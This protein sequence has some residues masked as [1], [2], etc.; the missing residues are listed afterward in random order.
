[1][2]IMTTLITG[3]TGFIG[4]YVVRDLLNEGEKVVAYDLIPQSNSMSH[5]LPQDVI[6]DLSIVQGEI[7]DHH[8]LLQT[9]KEYGVTQIVHLASPLWPMAQGN[10]PKAL[11]DMC[12]G[13]VN[14]LETARILDMRRVVWGSSSAV[15]G[16]R[17]Q[18]PDGYVA[19]DAPHYPNS[20]YGACKSLCEKY[21]EQY[22]D[23]YNLDTIGLRFTMVYGVGRLRGHATFATNLLQFPAIGEE[24]IVGYSDDIIDWQYVEDVAECIVACLKAPT[25]KTRVFTVAGEPRPVMD[26]VNY[27]KEL[28]PDAKLKLEKGTFGLPYRY[29]TEP[30]KEEVQFVSKWP[31]KKG[32]LKAINLFR[33]AEGL[34]EIELS[35]K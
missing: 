34:P 12:E 26:A 33:K 30:L 11:K 23:L 4:S 3:G 21:A 1:M 24:G 13:F 20:I 31:M 19:N 7:T 9:C 5:V 28:I 10:P 17:E 15:F 35:K 2:K 16:S 8:K 32:I 18:Y 14:I 27:V 25:T 22:F 6:D 29:D